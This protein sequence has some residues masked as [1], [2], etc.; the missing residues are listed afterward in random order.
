MLSVSS[1]LDGS[2]IQTEG[3]SLENTMWANTVLASQGYVLA[4]VAYTGMET[5]GHLNDHESQTKI[6]KVDH[7]INKLSFMLFIF[8]LI[9]SF[10]IVALS[11]FRGNYGINFVRYM[12]LLSAIIPI[13]LRVNLDLGKL[14]YTKVGID[15]DDEIPGTIARTSTIPEELGRIQFLLTDKTGTLTQN[16][17]I[18][19]RLSLEFNDFDTETIQ[20]VKDMIANNCRT[21]GDC[22]PMV[23][24]A[25]R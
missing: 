16:D 10:T 25:E 6:G 22:G 20:E 13:S 18:F 17:M 14:Y 8:M 7:E 23:D 12:L 11:G 24:V 21:R 9:L 4:M 3:L 1:A 19:K 5:R 2:D 15:C